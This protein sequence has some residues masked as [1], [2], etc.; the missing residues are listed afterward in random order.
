MCFC[1]KLLIE[2][3]GEFVLVPA[4]NVCGPSNPQRHGWGQTI[5]LEKQN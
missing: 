3:D 4:G 5:G 2:L 1:S